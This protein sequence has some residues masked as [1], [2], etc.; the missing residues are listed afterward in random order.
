MGLP[1]VSPADQRTVQPGNR[2]ACFLSFHCPEHSS[3]CDSFSFV[4][5]NIL[6]HIG[7]DMCTD[8][9]SSFPIR[10]QIIRNFTTLFVILC[11]TDIM[12][13]GVVIPRLFTGRQQ[14]ATM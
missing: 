1:D 12:H 10:Q 13:S 7:M 4:C 9:S 6:G 3:I 8:F 2:Q 11:K 5:L 14:C